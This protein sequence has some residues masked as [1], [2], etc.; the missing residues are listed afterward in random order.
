VANANAKFQQNGANETTFGFWRS[1]AIG[2]EY[3]GGKFILPFHPI[4]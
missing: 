3:F 2:K 1:A 4:P